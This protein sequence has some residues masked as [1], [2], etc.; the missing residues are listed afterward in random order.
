MLQL[1]SQQSIP[2]LT[3]WFAACPT[4]LSLLFTLFLLQL[5]SIYLLTTR[6]NISFTGPISP[7]KSINPNAILTNN[8]SSPSSLATPTALSNKLTTYQTSK[9]KKES[10]K[11][12]VRAGI[13]KQKNGYRD[14]VMR[15]LGNGPT[16]ALLLGMPPISGYLKKRGKNIAVGWQRRFFVVELAYV[17]YY[18]TAEYGDE[19]PLAAIDIRQMAKIC[20]CKAPN[21]R[22]FE[23][24]LADGSKKY[25]LKAK[26]SG[27]GASEELARARSWRGLE[28][29]RAATVEWY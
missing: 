28:R 21:E 27:A 22:C 24:D 13:Q 19:N 14:S 17:K 23:F 2:E 20:V 12:G 5:A 15:P 1:F 9:A 8:S 16:A 25:T 26:V 3:A 6:T 10:G 29:E 4:P 7:L 11:D 18:E